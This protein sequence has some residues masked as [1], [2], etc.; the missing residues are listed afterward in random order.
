MNKEI[1]VLVKKN[2]GGEALLTCDGARYEAR[3]GAGGAVAK[4]KKREG[5][6]ATPLGSYPFRYVFWRGD[7][8]SLGEPAAAK[9]E[10]LL[11]GR[12]LTPQDGWCDDPKDK[13][14]NCLVALPYA[15]SCENLWRED[16]LYN[17]I[18]V[19]GFND[20]PPTPYGG[21]AIFLHCLRKDKTPTKG[22]VAIAQ[23]DLLELLR[24]CGTETNLI[25]ESR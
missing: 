2:S 11:P 18:I 12:A 17:L 21:S 20:N 24:L 25:I 16:E 15:A 3:I 22:C 1:R 5:D 13:N 8:L 19:L 7:R 9:P 4:E 23:R 6:G 14:Y 10:T